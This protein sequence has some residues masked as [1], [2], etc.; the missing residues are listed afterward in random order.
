MESDDISRVYNAADCVQNFGFF[1][2]YQHKLNITYSN[3]GG[4]DVSMG[5]GGGGM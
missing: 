1:K 2:I 3:M 5:V 4:V